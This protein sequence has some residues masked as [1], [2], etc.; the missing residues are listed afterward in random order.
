M[1]E[2]AL[3]VVRDLARHHEGGV[4]KALDG[5]SFTVG[6]GEVVALT[7][8]SGCGKSTL[9]ALLGLLD[10]PTRGRIVVDDVDLAGVRDAAA[11]RARTVG[12]VFQSHHMVP[13]MTLRENVAAPMLPLGLDRRTRLARA[14]ALLEAVGLAHRARALPS[15]VSGGVRQR[16]AVARALANDPHLLLADEPTGNLDSA[17]GAVVVDL[18]RRA[19]RARGAGVLI[20]THNADVAAAADRV[21]TLRDGRLVGT[22]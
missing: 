6:G 14:E 20:A 5:V 12:F 9:L 13:T 10:R 21:L 1:S 22:G 15:R 2:P 16:A 18:L 3:L 8:P 7:G 11:F 19:A 4:V 17:S